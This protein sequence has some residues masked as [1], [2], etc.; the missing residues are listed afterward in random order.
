M[1]KNYQNYLS[2]VPK[3]KQ[4]IVWSQNDDGTVTLDVENK[5][6]F[7]KIAQKFFKKPK[8]SHI[9]LDENGSLIWRLID[10]KKDILKIGEL[11]ENCFGEK[12][13]PTY[14]RLVKFL[15]VL[16]NCKFIEWQK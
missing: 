4:G 5:G 7:N 16:N 2:K 15:E 11:A 3:R 13:H 1:V 9:R 10:G 6:V 14:E 12:V 8:I